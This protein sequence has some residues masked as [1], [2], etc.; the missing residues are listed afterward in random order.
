MVTSSSLHSDL[1]VPPGEY[2]AEVIEELG[3]T[4]ADLAARMGRPAQAV[5]EIVLG[6]KAITPDTAIQLEKVTSVPAHIWTGLEDEYRLVLA[7]A[8]EQAQ[9]E[10]DATLVDNDVYRSM[11][12]LGWLEST[13]KPADRARALCEFF[14]AATLAN[15][16]D[17]KLPGYAF[18]VASRGESTSFA[19]AAWLRRAEVSARGVEVSPFDAVG[20]KAAL[21]GLVAVTVRPQLHWSAAASEILADTGVALVVQPHLPKSY[22]NGATFWASPDKAVVVVSPRGSWADTFWFTLFHELGH[23]LLHRKREPHISTGDVEDPKEVEA[24]EFAADTLI[25]R[26]EYEDFVLTG[27]F[28]AADVIAFSEKLGIAPGLVVGRLQHERHLP[29]G[30]LNHLRQ[31]YALLD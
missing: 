20:L 8:A 4:Q 5:N 9:M 22:A 17:S 21:Q 27:N 19:L 3:M 15:V 28:D 12:R 13:K 7:R 24:N 18:R 30:R 1:A 16:R 14:G 29:Q 31:K 25:P 6:R 2:L 23:V 10:Q 11:V 26:R